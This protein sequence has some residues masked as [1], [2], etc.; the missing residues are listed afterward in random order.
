MLKKGKWT[1][2]G[3]SFPVQDFRRAYPLVRVQ[4]EVRR[5]QPHV[6]RHLFLTLL[7][8]GIV[9]K[10]DEFDYPVYWTSREHCPWNIVLCKAASVVNGTMDQ[11]PRFD[12][13]L[14]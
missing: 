14:G 6:I 5:P 1:V 13:A 7:K 4:G 2:P 9:Q 11:S 3:T 10:L 12:A 8:G